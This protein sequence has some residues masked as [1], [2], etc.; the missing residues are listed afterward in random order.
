MLRTLFALVVFAAL[1]A[2]VLA[3]ESAGDRFFEM[4][5][6]ITHDGRMDALQARFRDHTNKI[7]VKHGIT[8]I[9]YWV[10][11]EGPDAANTLVYI[12]AARPAKL[13]GRPFEPT[14]IGWPP[15]KPRKRTARS[16]KRSSS[17]S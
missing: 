8:P 10:P 12:L 9:G 14:P 11:T 13:R 5:T 15:R 2:P 6:Y 1:S 17:S 3:A 16:S 7:F 4:R